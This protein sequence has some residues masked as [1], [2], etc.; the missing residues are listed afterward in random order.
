MEISKITLS[1]WTEK[2]HADL[3][4]AESAKDMYVV[5]ERIYD[6][7][8][9]DIVQVCGPIATGGLGSLEANLHAFNEE[10]KNS[11]YRD[12][13]YLTKCFLSIRCKS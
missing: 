5:A 7:M 10:I 11:K 4:K 3:E 9:D 12:C 8:P 2:D 1:Y 6:R 13:M